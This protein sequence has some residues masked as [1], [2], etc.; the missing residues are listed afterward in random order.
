MILQSLLISIAYLI[1]L[2]LLIPVLRRRYNFIVTRQVI[3][4]ALLLS[5]YLLVV[6]G[7]GLLD[8]PPT[9]NT[10]L[11]FQ[12]LWVL[13]VVLVVYSIN[14]LVIWLITELVIQPGHL[15]IPKFVLNLLGGLI[16]GSAVL[17][18][19]RILFKVEL[20]GI[21]LT[22]TVASAII[23]FSIQDTLGNL[24]AGI[25][26]QI[27]SPFAID[28]WVEIGGH[29]GQVLSQNWRTLMLLTRE[30]HRVSL[31]N[32]DV[33]SDKII[34]YSRPTQRQIQVIY[35]QLDYSHPPNKVK[36]I[37]VD[38]LNSLDECEYDPNNPPFVAGFDD[39]AIRYG[40]R[41]WIKDYGDMITIKDLVYTRLWYIFKREGINIPFPTAVQ[42]EYEFPPSL[43]HTTAEPA[44]DVP[45][46]LNSFDL[47]SELEDDQIAQLAS[48]SHA[49]SFAIGEYLVREGEQGDSM[50]MITAGS[51]D[52]HIRGDQNQNILVQQKKAGE[53][54]G[55]MSLLTGEP[56]SATV[57]AT[58][59]VEVIVINKDAFTSVLMEDPSILNMLLDGLE[60][61]KV[62]L[63]T[64]RADKAQ[65]NGHTQKSSRDILIQRVWDYLGLS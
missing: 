56:R 50:F 18:A 27:E 52:I 12:I 41:F 43:N 47:I 40:L 33:A 14:Q 6:Y 31:T 64:Q 8:A 57:R 55:E 53:F 26:L 38:F 65:Q 2:F 25:A 29:E 44:A 34:N 60:A 21:L 7:L 51:V 36:S 37:M 46:L 30:N 49:Q 35:I 54:F 45:K 28:D 39:Y 15:K 22:S 5:V 9:E 59:D 23:G 48:F 10:E 20:S 17:I 32:K 13:L 63:Q 58:D 61:Q 16:L 3:F 1:L 4:P 24:F 42:Y 11:P 62:N 19:L